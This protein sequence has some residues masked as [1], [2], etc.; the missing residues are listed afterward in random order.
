[1]S[2]KNVFTVD[3]GNLE[4]TAEHQKTINTAIQSAVAKELSAIVTSNNVALVPV[5][6]Y[7]HGPIIN[8]IIAWERPDLVAGILREAAE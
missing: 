3:L 4:L 1:M 8:G 5:F 2:K 7:P 6:H